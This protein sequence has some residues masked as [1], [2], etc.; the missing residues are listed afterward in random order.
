MQNGADPILVK[1]AVGYILDGQV[2][3]TLRQPALVEVLFNQTTIPPSVMDNAV[4]FWNDE[5]DF[6]FEY[7]VAWI[8]AVHAR[9]RDD[10]ERG[11]ELEANGERPEGVSGIIY[12]SFRA[13]CDALAQRLIERKIGAKPYHAGMKPEERIEC[14]AKWVANEPGY[15]VIVATTAFGMGIDKE[16][17][18]FV[19]HYNLPKSFE[20]FY[21]EAGRAGRDGRASVCLQFYSREDA[22]RARNRISREVGIQPTAAKLKLV[23]NKLKSFDKV[24]EYCESTRRCKHNMILDYFAKPEAANGASSKDGQQSTTE[25]DYACDHCKDQSDLAER[26]KSGLAQ[27]EWVSTQRDMGTFNV[28]YY[29]SYD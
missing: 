22:E 11:A 4:Q 15:E 8:K 6:R 2:S 24:T 17:V 13:D 27:E 21:Q 5:D 9:R 28:D 29:E 25:C 26:K 19:M 16:D 1:D 14:Q 23:E 12:A 7:M 3:F 20:G 10:P 18:R